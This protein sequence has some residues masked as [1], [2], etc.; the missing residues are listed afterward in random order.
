MKKC[1]Q[2]LLA[3][4]FAGSFSSCA[5]LSWVS[6]D[7]TVSNTG[8]SKIGVPGNGTMKTTSD[9]DDLNGNRYFIISGKDSK[10]SFKYISLGPY[11][12]LTHH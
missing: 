1:F 3:L 12:G 10:G 8:Y 6:S 2:T 4:I 5:H 9:A 7:L 11:P